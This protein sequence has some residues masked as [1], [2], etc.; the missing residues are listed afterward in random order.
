M[1]VAKSR[2]GAF[3]GRRARPFRGLAGSTTS[4]RAGSGDN[5]RGRCRRS[6]PLDRLDSSFGQFGSSGHTSSWTVDACGSG[7]R[8]IRAEQTWGRGSPAL[9]RRTRGDVRSSRSAHP[10]KSSSRESGTGIL[11]PASSCARPSG[12]GAGRRGAGSPSGTGGGASSAAGCNKPATGLGNAERGCNSGRS[13]GRL[14]LGCKRKRGSRAL[15]G[16]AGGSVSVSAG[17]RV[18]CATAGCSR[19]WGPCPHAR[20]AVADAGLGPTRSGGLPCGFRA[21]KTPKPAGKSA[22]G[23][24]PSWNC[25]EK[26]RNGTE[27]ARAARARLGDETRCAAGRPS[28]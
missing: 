5:I 13:P 22:R 25:G 11:S 20:L 28:R 24:R 23:V 18:K 19:A 8:V 12:N 17:G 16:L 9:S 4:G 3:E 26:P 6:L 15:R 14:A 27:L 21:D 2:T 10:E 7:G 1:G